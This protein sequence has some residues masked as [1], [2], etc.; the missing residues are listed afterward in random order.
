MASQRSRI[1]LYPRQTPL[2]PQSSRR[3]PKRQPGGRSSDRTAAL[4]AFA[5]RGAPSPKPGQR[6]P[7]GWR[8]TAPGSRFIPAKPLCPHSPS[9]HNQS[10]SP[11]ERAGAGPA[12]CGLV[13]GHP[14]KTTRDTKSANAR[15]RDGV[16]RRCRAVYPGQAPL[17]GTGKRTLANRQPGGRSGDR[18]AAL[19]AFAPRGAPPQHPQFQ[20]ASRPARPVNAI[21]VHPARRTR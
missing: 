4:R 3:S 17:A 15:Q 5:P 1:T 19:R 8:S 16:R 6:R 20:A 14:A 12:A 7:V 2:P 21:P 10:A 9:R 11:P 13:P 18:A